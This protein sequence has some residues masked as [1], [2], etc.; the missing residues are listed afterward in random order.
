MNK[1]L[2]LTVEMTAVVLPV[3][4]VDTIIIIDEKAKYTKSSK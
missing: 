3:I 2:V 1:R 4:T